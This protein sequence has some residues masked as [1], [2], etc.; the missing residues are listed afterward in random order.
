MSLISTC[1]NGICVVGNGGISLEVINCLQNKVRLIWAVKQGHIG[2]TFFS[3]MES[4]FMMGI[5]FPEKDPQ[6]GDGRQENRKEFSSS[7]IK[8]LAVKKSI[9]FCFLLI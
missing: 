9:P 2:S 7:E 5:I 8:S 4:A 3:S 6:I 1:E